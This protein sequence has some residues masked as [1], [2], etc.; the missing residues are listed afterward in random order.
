MPAPT[1]R[2]LGPPAL[3][4]CREGADTFSSSSPQIPGTPSSPPGRS[5]A[6]SCH[7]EGGGEWV[8]G[9]PGGG[10]VH[11]SAWFRLAQGER[12]FFFFGLL[13]EQIRP[14]ILQ[15]S[16][17]L[18]VKWAFWPPRSP[19]GP[20]VLG[21]C[22]SDSSFSAHLLSASYI[23]LNLEWRAEAQSPPP[24]F[25]CQHLLDPQLRP[26]LCRSVN[27]TPSPGP[28]APTLNFLPSARILWYS[29]LCLLEEGLAGACWS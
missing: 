23:L 12:R 2:P 18:S 27:P 6:L 19:P 8:V 13:V 14:S 21:T 7:L 29:L 3:V 5:M 24:L 1:E 28:P 20:I 26:V 9:E 16:V 4:A 15:A 11:F 22:G 17:T 10:K 25:G